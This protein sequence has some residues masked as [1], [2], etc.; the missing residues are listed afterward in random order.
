[1][2]TTTRDRQQWLRTQIDA[3]KERFADEAASV[4]QP[5]DLQVDASDSNISPEKFLADAVYFRSSW[6]EYPP[7]DKTTG[8]RTPPARI[9]AEDL[10]ALLDEGN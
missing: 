8:F 9:A 2:G 4:S 6:P 7:A 3:F 5:C 10:V 1:M